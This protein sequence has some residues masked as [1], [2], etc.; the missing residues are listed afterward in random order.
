MK[1]GASEKLAG[2]R[3]LNNGPLLPAGRIQAA[4]VRLI[5]G[6]LAPRRAHQGIDI[7]GH[8]KLDAAFKP[9]KAFLGTILGTNRSTAA[10]K[11]ESTGTIDD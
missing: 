7:V 2:H 8:C 11:H 1:S 4:D 3:D 5:G 9:S 6:L 10:Q